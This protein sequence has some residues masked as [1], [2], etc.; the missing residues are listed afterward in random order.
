MSGLRTRGAVTGT[1]PCIRSRIFIRRSPVPTRSASFSSRE[2]RDVID[3]SVIGEVPER[4]ARSVSDVGEI[5]QQ[6]AQPV[7]QAG[8]IADGVKCRAGLVQDTA[9]LVWLRQ[10]REDRAHDAKAVAVSSILVPRALLV[11]LA[12]AVLDVAA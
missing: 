11:R 12:L 5:V 6:A 3:G 7:P 4:H 9:R 10:C 2:D 1:G 8:R